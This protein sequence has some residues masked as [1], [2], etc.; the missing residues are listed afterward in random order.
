MGFQG[1]PQN[2]GSSIG[3]NFTSVWLARSQTNAWTVYGMRAGNAPGLSQAILDTFGDD[4]LDAAVLSPPASDDA[5]ALGEGVELIHGLPA[6]DPLVAELPPDALTGN[7]VGL[8]ATLGYEAAPGLS[9]MLAEPICEGDDNECLSRVRSPFEAMALGVE[10]AL[11]G[12]P[13]TANTITDFLCCAGV[14]PPCKPCVENVTG[15]AAIVPVPAWT[16]GAITNIQGASFVC[17]YSRTIGTETI[18]LS[19]D[20]PEVLPCT[21]CGGTFTRPRVQKATSKELREPGVAMVCP[22]QPS[23][24]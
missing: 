3:A 6:D 12:A 23:Q 22:A 1:W 18:T 17:N 21:P 11:A 7:L 14:V 8:L 9:P 16:V 13:L 15:Y 2:E 19:G 4:A 24:P 20:K 5:V 10:G